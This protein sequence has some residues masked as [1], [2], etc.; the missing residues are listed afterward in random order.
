MGNFKYRVNDK[1]I[2]ITD[3]T[4]D[5]AVVNIPSEIEGKS[6]PGIEDCAFDLCERLTSVTIPDSVTS[7]GERAFAHC[8]NL[9]SVII[10]NHVTSIGERAFFDCNSLKSVIIPDSM[11]NIGAYAFNWCSNLESI[12]IPDSV[13]SIGTGAFFGCCIPI[14]DAYN[15]GYQFT[16]YGTKGSVAESYANENSFKFIDKK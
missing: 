5:D 7:I 13:V 16:I 12:T 8:S 4:G 14:D 9:T 2:V 11:I 10:P 6:V 1:F 15:K 3:Y